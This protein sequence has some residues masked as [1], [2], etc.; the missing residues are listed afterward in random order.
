MIVRFIGGPWDDEVRYVRD[1]MRTV[2]V[3]QPFVGNEAAYVYEILKVGR[4]YYALEQGTGEVVT[5]VTL[6]SRELDF[7]LWHAAEQRMVSEL[8]ERVIPRTVMAYRQEDP[9]SDH[10]KLTVMALA[11]KTKGQQHDHI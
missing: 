7:N 5:S 10:I 9:D 8:S 11:Q 6:W 3:A 2:R 1:S 4:N